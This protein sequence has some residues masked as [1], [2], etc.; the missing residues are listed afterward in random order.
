MTPQRRRQHLIDAA[1]TLFARI[2]PEQVSVDDVTRAADVSRALFYRYFSNIV[3]LRVAALRF[4]VDELTAHISAPVGDT[5]VDQL[6]NAIEAFL[7]VTERH[8]R[9]YVA[10]L[11]ADSVVTSSEADSLIEGVR[12]LIVTLIMDRIDGIEHTPLL[13]MTV[14][15]WV[16]LAENATVSW[17]QEP[18]VP[19]A[20][21]VDWLIGQL[22]AMVA[23]SARHEQLASR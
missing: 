7:D 8:S 11:R 10:L 5:L 12:Q 4:V 13:H 14:Q 9:A 17:Q 6:R 1:L 16:A 22:L 20:Q 18:T 19:R 2:G 15:G 23:A 3:E 21:L